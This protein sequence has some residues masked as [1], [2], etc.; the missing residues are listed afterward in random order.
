MQITEDNIGNG[1]YRVCWGNENTKFFSKSIFT[2][3]EVETAIKIHEN[4]YPIVCVEK[5]CPE[6]INLNE[7]INLI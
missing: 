1:Y 4:L 7:V 2:K 6:K 5:V 3:K